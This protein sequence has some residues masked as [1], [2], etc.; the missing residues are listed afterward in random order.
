MAGTR[1]AR[2]F[3]PRSVGRSDRR[4]AARARR[5]RRARRRGTP[6][7]PR[8][9]GRCPGSSTSH[10]LTADIRGRTRCCSVRIQPRERTRDTRRGRSTVPPTVPP[11]Q[12]LADRRRGDQRDPRGGDERRDPRQQVDGDGEPPAAPRGPRR[13]VAGLGKTEPPARS[14]A[15]GHPE[16]LGQ[17]WTGWASRIPNWARLGRD[18]WSSRPDPPRTS[19]GCSPRY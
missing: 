5:W 13:D 10:K 1:R 16:L 9:W 6:R 17:T 11:A 4:R 15:A 2:P 18:G 3:G 12:D 7:C 14:I 8:P 19:G